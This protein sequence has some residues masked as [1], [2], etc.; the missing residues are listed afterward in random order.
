MLPTTGNLYELPLK[1]LEAVTTKPKK[2][3]S[4]LYSGPH[5]T[6]KK[7]I[8]YLPVFLEDCKWDFAL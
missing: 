4:V 6:L 2:I 5:F 8:D 3:L 1:G 7:K